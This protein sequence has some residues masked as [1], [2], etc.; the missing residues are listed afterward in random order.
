MTDYRKREEEYINNN[1]ILRPFKTNYSEM[2]LEQV[3]T[4][5]KHHKKV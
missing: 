1:V 5:A 3:E 2:L 4:E